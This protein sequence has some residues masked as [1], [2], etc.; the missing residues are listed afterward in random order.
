MLYAG[1]VFHDLP[2]PHK[3]CLEPA[4]TLISQMVV[5]L[6]RVHGVTQRHPEPDADDLDDSGFR[7][8][9]N[10]DVMIP[11][12]RGEQDKPGTGSTQMPPCHDSHSCS[13]E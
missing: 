10:S 4:S 11:C 13:N 5:F 8:Q 2:D 7:L 6:H 12:Q 1:L 3:A 9:S